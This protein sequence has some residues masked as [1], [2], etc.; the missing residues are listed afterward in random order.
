MH[1]REGWL[2]FESRMAA[3]SYILSA[4][5][6]SVEGHDAAEFSR[7]VREGVH[8]AVRRR[9]RATRFSAGR[10]SHLR[11]RCCIT[12]STDWP[13]R[14]SATEARPGRC[15]S[16]RSAA[17][18]A[19]CRRSGTR[20]RRTERNGRSRRH[21]SKSREPRAESAGSRMSTLRVGDTGAC[22]TWGVGVRAADVLRVR[23]LRIG[24]AVEALAA[25]GAARGS[26]I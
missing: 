7:D 17:E 11:I 1:Y 4:S 21:S 23:G 24:L 2:Y 22:S 12:R 15:R 19:S 18:C 25:A 5:P 26:D 3:V 13:C 10:C 20:W 9:S 16:F 8:R 14:I 6:T